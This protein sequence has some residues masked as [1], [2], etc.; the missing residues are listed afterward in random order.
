[1]EYSAKRVD[2]I[3][4]EAVEGLIKAEERKEQATEEGDRY[5]LGFFAGKVYVL[6]HLVTSLQFA[7]LTS[8]TPPPIPNVGS[9]A[10]VAEK[11]TTTQITGDWGI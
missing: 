6:K 9:G 1:M 11:G 10:K 7:S 5:D 3:F 4:H 2:W 8:E